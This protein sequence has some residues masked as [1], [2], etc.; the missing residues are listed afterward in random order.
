[1]VENKF[2]FY[3]IFKSCKNINNTIYVELDFFKINFFMNYNYNYFFNNYRLL[4]LNN[5]VIF[6]KSK[7]TKKINNKLLLEYSNLC[8]IKKISNKKNIFNIIYF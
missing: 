5:Y 4:F 2:S 7:I 1:M 3:N 8:Y 6:K